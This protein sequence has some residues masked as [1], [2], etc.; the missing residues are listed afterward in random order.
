MLSGAHTAMGSHIPFTSILRAAAILLE[1]DEGMRWERAGGQRRVG[2]ALQGYYLHHPIKLECYRTDAWS[3]RKDDGQMSTRTHRF[4]VSTLGWSLVNRRS[5]VKLLLTQLTPVGF[6][7]IWP[8]ICRTRQNSPESGP[9]SRPG[10]VK[11]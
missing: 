1:H 7:R 6:C 4:A 3:L 2:S 5:E 9:S 8:R 10:S 11:V